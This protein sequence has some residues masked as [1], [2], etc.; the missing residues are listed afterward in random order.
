[1]LHSGLSARLCNPDLS[2]PRVARRPILGL[3]ANLGAPCG[4]AAT[5]GREQVGLVGLECGQQF[6]RNGGA[7]L[8]RPVGGA[9]GGDQLG[10]DG[11]TVAAALV[12]PEG[13][14]QLI[15]HLGTAR[16]VGKHLFECNGHV[17]EVSPRTISGRR[18]LRKEARVEKLITAETAFDGQP[19]R[20]IF[21][22]LMGSVIQKNKPDFI[23]LIHGS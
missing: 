3:D 5:R 8:A 13:R 11:G 14:D 9:E 17:G 6:P 22:H 1:M 15:G 12:V 2:L 18:R 16:H 10:G 20:S 4:D 7:T 21:L 19:I 23:L